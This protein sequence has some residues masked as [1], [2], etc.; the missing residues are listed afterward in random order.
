MSGSV[1][2]LCIILIFLLCGMA[3]TGDLRAGQVDPHVLILNSY[4]QGE[5]WSDNEIAGVLSGLQAR[6]PYLT[7]SIEHLDAK[8]FPTPEHLA[9]MRDHL[10]RKYR[11]RRPDLV[12]VLDNPAFDLALDPNSADLFADAPVVFAGVNGFR[13]EMIAGRTNITGAAERQDMAGTLNMAIG[14]HPGV[15]RVLAVHD[16]TDSGLAVRR[17]MEAIAPRF[18]DKVEI[19][20]SPDGPLEVL[21]RE[22]R[23][24]KAGELVLLLSY[25]TDQSGRTFTRGE[26]TRIIT[27]LSPVPVYAMHETRLGHGIAGGLLLNGVEHG[28]Q[29]AD[30]A[31][32]VLA[33][34]APSRIPVEDS[35]S[36]PFLDYEV[37]TRFNIP[38]RLWPPDAE[39]I[40]RPVS[41]WNE[42]SAALLP[43]LWVIGALALLAS[44]L[45]VTLARMRRAEKALKESNSLLLAT[46][47][48]TADGILAVDTAGMATCCNRRFL[49]MWRIPET[50]ATVRDDDRLLQ[51]VLDRIAHPDDFLDRVREIYQK[52]G[53][54]S[55][56]ELVLKDG[57]IFERYSLPQRIDD[58]IVGRVWSF[59]DVTERENA[60]QNLKK[61]EQQLRRLLET[62]N[63]VPWEFDFSKDRFTY[64]GPQ[65]ERLLGYPA[66]SW[67][68]FQSWASRIDP[69]DREDAVG[70]C[71]TCTARGQDH[72]FAY[73]VVASDGRIVW[74]EDIVTVLMGPDGPEGLVGFM[75]DITAQKRAEQDLR[76]SEEQYRFLVNSAGV[77][78]W[79][80]D[81]D[82]FQFTFVSREAENLLGYP[83]RQWME[84]P[85]F[86]VNHLHPEDRQRCMETCREAIEHGISHEFEYRMIGAGGRVVWVRDIVKLKAEDGEIREVVGVL[87]D[88]TERKQAEESLRLSEQRYRTVADYTYDWEYW[89]GPDGKMIYVSPSCERITGYSAE[90]FIRDPGLVLSVV[91]PDDRERFRDHLDEPNLPDREVCQDDYRIITRGGE[92]RWINHSCRSV[93]GEDGTCLGRRAGNRDITDRVTAMEEKAKVEAQLRHAQKMEAIGTLAG[94]IAHDFN[95]ILSPIIGFTEMAL[96]EIPDSSP[97]R[98]DLKQVLTAAHRAKELA[99]QILSF[100]RLGEDPLMRPVDVSVIVKEAL[101]LLRASLPSSI[102]IRED[103]R[104][105][106]VLADAIQI[107]Q[108]I[109][110]LCTNAAHAMEDQ[111]I[112]RVSLTEASL[113]E[114]D[115][116]T[117]SAGALKPGKHLRLSVEDTGRGMSPD[118]IQRIFEPYFTTKEIGK[119]TGLG[120][121]VVHGI[122]KRH[123]GEILVR[124]EL[125]KGSV[126]EV[127]LPAASEELRPQAGPSRGMPQGSERILLV[128]DEPMVARMGGKMLESL[129]Y[130]VTTQTNP[131]DALDIFRSNPDEFDLVVTDYT[132]PHMVGTE[133]AEEMMRIRQ[134]IPIIMFTGFSERITEEDARQMGIEGFAMKPLDK[135]RLAE[136]VRTV[137]DGKEQ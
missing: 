51:V 7:P 102:E 118:T 34:E 24:M 4:H 92:V 112:L 50:P 26:S 125:G 19:V 2:R 134:G 1:G 47:E 81:P 104:K 101:K 72:E 115:L 14:L 120:L 35:L 65:I 135:R 45:G 22:L 96:D 66:S 129:G 122:V 61:K 37:L 52:P 30:L 79:R 124:S 5:M 128:D 27:S 69:R 110:N 98:Y 99:K 60:E 121:S 131:R 71:R 94:G 123:G 106:M 116:T 130:R 75:R 108:V 23:A 12:V 70:F 86:W 82:S 40:G 97:S 64:M 73:R 21:A 6:Y 25:V 44:L 137:L 80:G 38:E 103:I 55:K 31:V 11:N 67:S 87:V 56:D 17:D 90:D 48:S 36:R 114:H 10:V 76:E 41:F 39:V 20:F 77:V 42:H 68:D 74:I 78:V 29:A 111:G 49:E 126:F 117:L 3:R 136:L 33:G 91:H 18:Q 46:L 85:D 54:D 133:L 127:F 58:A 53:A 119:G 113:D 132:M 16:Y 15:T 8:R 59:R 100:S 95:N 107:H 57:R 89:I 105:V 63:S 28:A 84:E 13:Q 9:F 43:A 93:K 32:R 88:I 109:V 83:A 62:T